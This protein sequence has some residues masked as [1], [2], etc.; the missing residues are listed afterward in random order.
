MPIQFLQDSVCTKVCLIPSK[1]LKKEVE[2][3]VRFPIGSSTNDSLQKIPIGS[4]PTNQTIKIGKF[5]I[6]SNP[7]NIL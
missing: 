7:L 6:G 3:N 4:N 2:V 1:E 5:P